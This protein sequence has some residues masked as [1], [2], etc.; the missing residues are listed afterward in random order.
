MDRLSIWQQNINKSPVCQHNI[1]SNNFLV[2]KGINL[3]ALQEPAISGTGLSITSRDWM[4]VYPSKQSNNPHNT[5]SIMLIGADISTENWNQIDFP[6]R[7]V[8]VV[9]MT[10]QW[11]KITIFNIYNDGEHEDMIR[12]LTVFH[13]RN[14]AALERAEVGEAHTI[15]LGDFNRHHPAWDSPEDH[16]LFTNEAMEAAEKLIEAVADVGLELALPSGTPTHKHSVTKRWSRLDQVFLTDHS[17]DLL[18]ICDTQPEAR[19]INMDHLPIFTELNLEVATLE[20]TSTYNFRG[21]NWEDFR[22]ELKQQLDQAAAPES[23]QNQR[24]LDKS[25]AELTD[26]LQE[27]IRTQVPM[28]ENTPKSKRWWTRELTQLRARA[29]KLG[30]ASFKL[31]NIPE[32]R[33][34]K[35]HKEA[36]GEY[37]KTLQNT[38]QQHWRE[39]LEKA[40]DLDIWA[41]N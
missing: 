10:E 14:R 16:R 1:I 25:C 35:E 20:S 11:G 37:Q 17:G 18:T 5:R 34:H 22:K 6:S 21:V 38:K 8:T 7:D 9:Q 3:I 39:W 15:W 12:L 19:G 2:R 13:H 30:R 29:N 31:R 24:H 4:P 32:H 40:E 28:I 27:A 26:V 41:A 23:I 36:K 33:V